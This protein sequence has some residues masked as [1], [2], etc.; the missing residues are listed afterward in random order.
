MCVMGFH[1]YV[2]IMHI[3]CFCICVGSH[4]PLCL[5]N[6]LFVVSNVGISSFEI[7]TLCPHPETNMLMVK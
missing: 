6:F 4:Y 1:L 7:L 5:R 2:L 3:V